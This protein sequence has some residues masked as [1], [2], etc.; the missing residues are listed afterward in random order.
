MIL[1][2]IAMAA[3]MRLPYVYLGYWVPGSAKMDYKSALPAAG[4]LR[5][6]P[7]GADRPRPTAEL[8]LDRRRADAPAISEQVA[9]IEL[10]LTK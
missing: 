5:R 2:H 8:S 3:E 1:D 10:P 4:D 9:A 6:R 7:L